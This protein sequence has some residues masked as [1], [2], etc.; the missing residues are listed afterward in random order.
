MPKENNLVVERIDKKLGVILGLLI[1]EKCEKTGERIYFLYKHGMDYK[2][3]ADILGIH[4]KN[5][6]REISKIKGDK[7]VK[8]RKK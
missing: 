7:S 1:K 8:K 2:E 4:P 3:I 5:A 6:A